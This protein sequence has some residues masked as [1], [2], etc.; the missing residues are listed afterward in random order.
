MDQLYSYEKLSIIHLGEGGASRSH[1][2]QHTD[3]EVDSSEEPSTHMH[4]MCD[5][6]SK[7]CSRG[8]KMFKSGKM[9]KSGY[10]ISISWAK[11]MAA[12]L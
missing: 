9:I 11:S 12:F 7:Y 5:K 10:T 6:W 8:R 3:D 1:S 4:T 2:R